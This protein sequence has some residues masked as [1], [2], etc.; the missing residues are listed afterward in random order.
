MSQ[1][2]TYLSERAINRLEARKKAV[3]KQKIILG[4][5]TIFI[6]SVIVLLGSSIHAFA[7]SNKDQTEVHKYYK[8]IKV[9]AGDSLWDIA[10]DYMSQ[11][12]MTK[13]E[14]I[15]EI[16]KINHINE[17]DIHAGDSIIV[18]YYTTTLQ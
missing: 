8:S 14:Y 3:R 9:E 15:E 7:N 11:S 4:M 12:D 16:C 10:D 13:K 5:I 2:S 18:A 1:G 6:I 17:N